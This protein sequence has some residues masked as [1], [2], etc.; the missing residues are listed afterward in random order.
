MNLR[1]KLLFLLL[2]FFVVDVNVSAGDTADTL[3]S[4]HPFKS[5]KAKAYRRMRL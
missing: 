4:H 3:P 5:P 2:S 1:A